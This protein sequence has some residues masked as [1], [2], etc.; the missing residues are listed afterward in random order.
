MTQAQAVQETA[1]PSAAVEPGLTTQE[2]EDIL[3]STYPEMIK[4]SSV[5]ID[6]ELERQYHEALDAIGAWQ[7]RLA[8]I[9]V[10][11]R[12]RLGNAQNAVRADGT[13]WAQRRVYP[14]AEYTVP[15][16]TVDAIYPVH[17]K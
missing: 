10:Q 2:M 6:A 17:R 16:S 7:D 12:H 3:R 11:I 14:R 5:E 13:A 8:A 9:R 4:K 15:A 1:M